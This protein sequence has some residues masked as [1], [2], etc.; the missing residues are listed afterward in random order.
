MS[1]QKWRD[2]EIDIIRQNNGDIL[3]DTDYEAIKNSIRNI[4]LT[5]QGTRR[6]LP[7][8]AAPFQFLL[9][10]PIDEVTANRLGEL[11]LMAIEKWEDRVFIE[12]I[13]VEADEDNNQYNVQLT[14]SMINSY[15]IEAIQVVIRAK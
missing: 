14:F 5:E 3:V 6:M 1:D 4:F 2:L 15:N 7:T 10:E 8:F 9:F 12:N 11:L 13:H